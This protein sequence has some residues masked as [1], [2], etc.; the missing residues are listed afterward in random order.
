MCYVCVTMCAS[1]VV[2]RGMCVMCECVWCV[3]CVRCMRC[4]RCVRCV[5]GVFNASV[6]VM[7]VC[8][9]GERVVCCV[10]YVR[11][12]WVPGGGDACA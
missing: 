8:V 4:A 2:W 5:R 10:W 11:G 12:A 9:V 3:C 7:C 1:G 6:C